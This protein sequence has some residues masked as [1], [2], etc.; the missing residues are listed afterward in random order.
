[1]WKKKIIGL[2][3][4]EDIAKNFDPDRRRYAYQIY[5]HKKEIGVLKKAIRSIRS[6]EL[7]VLDVACGTGR[8]LDAVFQTGKKIGYTGLDTSKS[9]TDILKKKAKTLGK[10]KN[11]KIVLAD[12]SKMPFKDNFFDIS[13]TYHLLW[14]IPEEDQEKVIREMIRVT[15]KDGFVLFDILNR[16]FLFDKIKRLFGIKKKQGLYKLTV[17]DVE[18]MIG[19]REKHVEKLLDAPIKND[20]LYGIFNVINSSNKILP[21][22]CFHMLY[23]V[24]KK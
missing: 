16:G 15:K 24:C 17:S 11:I 22:N 20:S 7:K 9:M 19:K 18:K 12:A 8:M 23:I 3:Q 21:K 14:H 5:K 13:Y 2:Y 10:T 6:D 1:M 4:Q